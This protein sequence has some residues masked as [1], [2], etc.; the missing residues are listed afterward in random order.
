MKSKTHVFLI[1]AKTNLHAGSG[2]SNFG[3]I[4]N[5]VQRD[6]ST[7][8]PCIHGSSLKGAI[9][10][11]CEEILEWKSRGISETVFGTDTMGE[12]KTKGKEFIKGSHGFFS[13][14]LLFLP[15][16][17]TIKPFFR[18][19]CVEVLHSFLDHLE[20]FRADQVDQI[21]EA[22][23]PMLALKVAKGAPLIFSPGTGMIEDWQALYKEIEINQFTRLFGEDTALLEWSDF[24]MLCDNNNLPVIARN[25]LENGESKNL[26]YEQIVPRESV[27]YTFVTAPENMNEIDE[28]ADEGKPLIQIGAN[29]TIGYGYCRFNLLK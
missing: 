12:R 14:H 10:E 3:I 6:P 19:T 7:K 25:Q 4:D 1:T 17:S 9:K 15:V 11:Y 24:E 28:I 16:R 5:L 23:A 26:W 8:L 29:A 27:F 13:A 22:L 20:H 2:D 21:R 18:A